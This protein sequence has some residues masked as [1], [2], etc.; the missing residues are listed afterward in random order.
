MLGGSGTGYAFGAEHEIDRSAV[1]RAS[2]R[3][4]LVLPWVDQVPSTAAAGRRGPP[5]PGNAK[6]RWLAASHHD[7]VGAGA[8]HAVRRTPNTP[9][10]GGDEDRH[11]LGAHV[12]A[13]GLAFPRNSVHRETGRLAW[14]IPV[15]RGRDG[16]R[17]AATGAQRPRRSTGVPCGGVGLAAP[18]LPP[19]EA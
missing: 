7:H 18:V 17:H 2:D 6:N 19:G 9:V 4:D 11:E 5:V 3:A 10:S 14:L 1:Q 15:L 13:A 12:E 16:Q 8:A